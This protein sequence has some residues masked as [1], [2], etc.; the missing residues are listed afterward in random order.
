M[1]DRQ[2]VEVRGDVPLDG[3]NKTTKTALAKHGHCLR[4]LFGIDQAELH[5]RE[6]ER[7]ELHAFKNVRVTLRDGPDASRSS[8]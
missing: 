5:I 8:K 6:S 4:L 2:R 3:E 1:L 7:R